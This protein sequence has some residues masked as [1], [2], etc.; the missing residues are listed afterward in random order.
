MIFTSIRHSGQMVS[1]LVILTR[2]HKKKR[3][4]SQK[5]RV[6]PFAVKFSPQPRQKQYRS[7]SR[8]YD[9]SHSN[10]NHF[11]SNPPLIHT[12]HRSKNYIGQSNSSSHHFKANRT[13][14]SNSQNGH[15]NLPKNHHRGAYSNQKN[16]QLQFTH[17]ASR[18]FQHQN[19]RHNNNSNQIRGERIMDPE[20]LTALVQQLNWQM[21]SLLNRR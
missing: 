19:T 7:Q 4:N 10:S 12:Q 1:R 16:H 5:L 17:H 13:H 15:S 8:S 20:Q 18:P 14:R 3:L 11:V 9:Y 2:D 6:N 21:N